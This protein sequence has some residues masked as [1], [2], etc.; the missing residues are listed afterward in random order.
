MTKRKYNKGCTGKIY[1][2]PYR[3][4][5]PHDYLGFGR[6]HLPA[7]Y[8]GMRPVEEAKVFAVIVATGVVRVI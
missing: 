8:V 1:A 7:W 6:Y 4:I 3:V 5:R 2:F